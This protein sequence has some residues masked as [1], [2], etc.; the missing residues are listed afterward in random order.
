MPSGYRILMQGVR[1][2]GKHTQAMKLSNIYGWRVVD[3]KELVRSKIEEM[4]KL[5][6]HIPNNP[7]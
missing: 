4:S 3:F 6:M 1:G 2:S 7:M 5:E